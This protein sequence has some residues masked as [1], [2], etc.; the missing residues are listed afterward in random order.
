MVLDLMGVEV[1]CCLTIVGLRK[2]VT[3]FGADISSTI[4]IGNKKK[5]LDSW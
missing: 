2:K 1:F 4:K 3:V 5:E